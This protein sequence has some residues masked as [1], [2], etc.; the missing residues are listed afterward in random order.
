MKHGLHLGDVFCK[1]RED[2]AQP[3]R[4]RIGIADGLLAHGARSAEFCDDGLGAFRARDSSLCAELHAVEEG[5]A[6]FRRF[7]ERVR[8][9]FQRIDEGLVAA[10]DDDLEVGM[11]LAGTVRNVVDF[12]AF[13][14]IGVHQ[15][16][17]VHISKMATR[18]VKHPSDVVTVGDTVTVW[19][20]RIDRERGK[21]SLSMVKGK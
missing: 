1:L 16:G 6:V 12:G 15:D 4:S 14:D 3:V 11:E 21:I 8:A 9:G 17:L 2:D 20:E 5:L 7:F 18:F 10:L 19:V 13:V